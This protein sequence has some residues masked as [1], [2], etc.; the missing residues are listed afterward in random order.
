MSGRPTARQVFEHDQL[1]AE[2][3]DLAT[4]VRRHWPNCEYAGQCAGDEAIRHV[5]ESPHPERLL[6]AA[7]VRLA[8]TPGDLAGPMG[9]IST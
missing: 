8:Q 2:V 5:V 9:G 1:M 6:L 3:N 7:L 4:K